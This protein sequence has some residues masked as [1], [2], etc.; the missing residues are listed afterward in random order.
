[1]AFALSVLVVIYTVTDGKS[2]YLEGAMV[3]ALS[4]GCRAGMRMN[5]Y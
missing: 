1:M 2:N 5:T 4:Q 3:S